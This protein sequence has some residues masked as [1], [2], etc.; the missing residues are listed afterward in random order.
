MKKQFI[1]IASIL[2]IAQLFI[3]KD[4]IP[5]TEQEVTEQTVIAKQEQIVDITSKIDS[6]IFTAKTNPQEWCLALNIYH[7]ARGSTMVDQVAVADVTLNRVEAKGYPSTICGVV[8]Q[9][10]LDKYGKPQ[11]NKC[12]FSWYCDD[13]TDL[14]RDR[15]AWINAQYLAYTMIHQNYFRGLTKGSTHYHAHY[16]KPRWRKSFDEVAQIGAHIYYK[17]KTN[18]I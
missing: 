15:K 7:E 4:D 9:A 16:V 10:H 3:F 12:Q 18:A 8:K 13:H 17:P 5:V 1:I 11:K 2:A 6:Q 14:P